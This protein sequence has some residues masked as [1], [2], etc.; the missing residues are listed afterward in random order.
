MK[1]G[2]Q[3]VDHFPRTTHLGVLGLTLVIGA[4]AV[5]L[6]LPRAA[7]ASGAA[8]QLTPRPTILP[9]T[10][11]PTVGCPACQTTPAPP[12]PRPTSIPCPSPTVSLS[13]SPALV[14]LP[15]TGG[16]AGARPFVWIGVSALLIAAG[17]L[18]RSCARR[19]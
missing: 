19:R 3:L 18:C 14:L 15:V 5:V 17:F 16:P 4:I 9:H 11:V 13:M 8:A 12:K 10:P 6:C 1:R 7:T 2:F